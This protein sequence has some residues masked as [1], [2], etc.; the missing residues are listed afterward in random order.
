M[1]WDQTMLILMPSH[2]TLV[3]IVYEQKPPLIVHDGVY[4][5]TR[6]PNFGLNLHL[7][8]LFM[9]ASSDGFVAWNENI[10]RRFIWCG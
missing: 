8:A 6:C 2:G 4:S 10:I 5:R 1:V 3:I 7:H 9:H